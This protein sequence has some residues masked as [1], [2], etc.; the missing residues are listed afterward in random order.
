MIYELTHTTTYDYVNSVSLSHHILRL[1]PRDLHRQKCL[2]NKLQIQP[3]AAVTQSHLDYFGNEVTFVTVEGPHKHLIITS[4][5]RIEA[6]ASATPKPS[7]TPAWETIGEQCLA[8]EPNGSVEAREF[9]FPSPRIKFQSEF[10]DYALP[11]FT[12][13]R[14][15][16]DAVLDLTR[17][18]HEDFKFDPKATTVATPLEQ[19]VKTRRGVCQDF[20]HF[21][22][23]CLRM[24]GVPARY[25]SGYLET[26][27][28]PGKPRLTGADASHA[29]ISFYCPDTGWIDVDP[30]NNLLPSTRHITVA[31]GRDYSDVSPIRGVILG[32]G[33]HTLK[34]AVDVIPADEPQLPL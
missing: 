6:H 15:V 2:R 22:I 24:M 23:A 18:I 13:G 21:E 25:V 19:V 7:E 1:H 9:L 17:R 5:S 31:W 8:A 12:A 29:W 14:P 3:A 33:E 28:P 34:V 32:S 4:R 20:A 16:L 27:P 26:D 30:T 11:S 10:A